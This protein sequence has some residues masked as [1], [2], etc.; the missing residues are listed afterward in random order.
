MQNAE[1]TLRVFD[2][3]GNLRK[4]ITKDVTLSRNSSKRIAEY[5]VNQLTDREDAAFVV[6]DL[7]T[8]QGVIRNDLFFTEYKKC[9]LVP[10]KVKSTVKEIK[11]KL[12]VS[13]ETDAPAF[14]VTLDAVG[15]SGEFD[16]NAVTLLPGEKRTLTFA[17]KEAVT[18]T[19]FGE[20]LTVR[21]LRETYK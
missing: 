6:V 16:D 21:H 1:M 4:K 12:T 11:G 7:K 18:Q 10:A 14:F 2:F 3:A 9:D 5:K 15:V 8:A 20:A 19:R 13:V 17:P